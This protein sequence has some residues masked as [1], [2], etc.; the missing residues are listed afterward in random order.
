MLDRVF[1]TL[2]GLGIAACVAVH[3]AAFLE[4]PAGFEV[5]FVLLLGSI[6]VW[7]RALRTAMAGVLGTLAH[8]GMAP[9]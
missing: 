7:W 2:A 3:A 4:L 5:T 1:L 8:K 9:E 6:L